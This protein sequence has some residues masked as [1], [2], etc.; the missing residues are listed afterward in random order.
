MP[1]EIKQN[2]RPFLITI[3]VASGNGEME[4]KMNKVPGI[5]N[6]KSMKNVTTLRKKR[7]DS[8]SVYLKLHIL[9]AQKDRLINEKKRWEDRLRQINK[10]L[11]DINIQ[12]SGLVSLTEKNNVVAEKDSVNPGQNNDFVLEY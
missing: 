11:A 4:V 10:E 9:M 1:L 12:I 8:Q 7:N 2:L 3:Y 5:R 6:I